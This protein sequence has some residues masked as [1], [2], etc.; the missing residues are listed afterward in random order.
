VGWRRD[1]DP[2]DALEVVT[3]VPLSIE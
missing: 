2:D 3:V 1:V